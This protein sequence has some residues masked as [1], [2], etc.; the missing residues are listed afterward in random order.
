M[1]KN[2]FLIIFFLKRAIFFYDIFF[3]IFLKIYFFYSLI[4]YWPFSKEK[5]IKKGLLFLRLKIDYIFLKRKIFYLNRDTN[6]EIN[7]FKIEASFLHL[8]EL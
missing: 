5:R 8:Y 7:S 6:L 2:C 4:S 3:M 1:R